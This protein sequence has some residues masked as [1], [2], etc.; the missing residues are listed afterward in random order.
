MTNKNSVLKK[1]ILNIYKNKS[2]TKIIIFSLSCLIIFVIIFLSIKS[3]KKNN[4][5][6]IELF[7]KETDK[8][9]QNYYK[10]GSPLKNLV[11]DKDRIINVALII[12][13][14]TDEE[15]YKIYLEAKERGMKFI[16]CSSYI[17]FPCVTK[18]KYDIT[19][20]SN[21]ISWNYDYMNLCFGW[22]HCFR[23][24]ENN[25][26]KDSMPK[27]LISESDFIRVNNDYNEN[28][29][30]EYD[31]IYICLKD[32]DNCDAGWQSENRN[33]DLAKKCMNIM[34]SKYK[35][36]GLLIGRINCEVPDSCHTLMEKTDF[37]DYHKF[38]KQYQ[39]CRFIFV[40]NILDASPRVLTEALSL[41]LPCLVNTNIVGGWKYVNN[42]TGMLFN[43]E[44]D[45]E[46]VLDVFLK[47]FN[48]YTPRDYFLKNHGTH[49][50]GKE[51]VEFIKKNLPNYKTELNIDLDTVEYLQPVV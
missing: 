17:N 12:Y 44:N 15:K 2:F 20:D 43:D 18:N 5:N 38:M 4:N 33:W 35:L 14:F 9:H 21:N 16:G 41:N 24:P 36:N 26:I 25:C 13:P 30:K 1:Y 8:N 50:E 49:K 28:A 45:F 51:I 22:F 31:F 27:A 42:Q 34:C 47:K 11:D 39:R 19:N 37:M 29:E 10:Y 46:S 7:N 48:T 23:D 3:K 32:N 6:V 40:P